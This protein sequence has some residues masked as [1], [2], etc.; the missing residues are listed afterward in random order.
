MT[1]E[2]QKLKGIYELQNLQIDYYVFQDT[3]KNIEVNEDQIEN[4]AEYNNSLEDR[5]DGT[6]GMSYN[7]VNID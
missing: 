2:I 1:L 7:I 4:K 5:L 3:Y 6:E